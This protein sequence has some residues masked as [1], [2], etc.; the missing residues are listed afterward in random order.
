MRKLTRTGGWAF[1]GLIAFIGVVYANPGNWVAAFGDAGFAKIAAAL[2]LVALGGSWLLYRRTL[3]LGGAVGAFLLGLFLLVGASATWSFWPRMSM[4]TFLDG[5][6]FFAI[7]FLAANVIDSESRLHTT[8]TALAWASLVPAL[9][10]I[11]SWSR[12]EHLVDGDRAAWIGIFANPNDLAYYLVVGVAMALTA[13][14]TSRRGWVRNLNLLLL[15]PLG[16]ALL[17]TQSRGGML[18]AGAVLLLWT[19]RSLRRA[20]ALLGVGIALMCVLQLA[21]GDPWSKRNEEASYH[22]EDLSARGRLDAWRT[23]LNMAKERPLSGVG[24]GAFVVAYPSFAPGDAGPA[25][26]E[27]NTFIQLLAEL[28]IPGLFLFLGAFGAGVVGVSRAAGRPRLAPYARGV[29]CGLCG[30]AVCSVSGGI[31]F[32]WPIYLLLGISVAAR[33]LAA[34]SRA[35]APLPMLARAA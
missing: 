29:Q 17:L 5:L 13:R 20:P 14:E 6:K 23:G 4:D 18:A 1:A 16:V 7:F 2:S 26:T 3:H 24:A 27:H 15:V 34:P 30:F 35:A 19:M 31:A 10:C 28:G 12:G 32:S 22:G 33:R 11:S 8:V 25:R 9:G 21:P